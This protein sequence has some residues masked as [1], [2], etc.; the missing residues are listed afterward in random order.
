RIDRLSFKA[1]EHVAEELLEVVIPEYVDVVLVADRQHDFRR[2]GKINDDG[3]WGILGSERNRYHAQR[4]GACNHSV[5]SGFHLF[6]SR[7]FPWKFSAR[8]SFF[9]C[10]RPPMGF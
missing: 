4:D 1:V 10:R 9:I 8:I 3:I 5:H 7:F 2:F 6:W